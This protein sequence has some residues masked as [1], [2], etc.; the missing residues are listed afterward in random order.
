M[1]EDR[2]F[3]LSWATFL[4]EKGAKDLAITI[5]EGAGPLRVLAAQ[6]MYAG[7][8]FF[9]QSK[10]SNPWYAFASMLDDKQESASFISFLREEV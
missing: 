5:L 7:I 10:P 3:W 9:N 8:P 4:R 1:Q 2:A 6:V